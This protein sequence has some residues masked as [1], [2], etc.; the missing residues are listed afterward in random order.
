MRAGSE[1]TDFFISSFF[2]IRACRSNYIDIA[3][4]LGLHLMARSNDVYSNKDVR[5]FWE[6]YT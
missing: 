4:T 2:P 5:A 1:H 6:E 3:E